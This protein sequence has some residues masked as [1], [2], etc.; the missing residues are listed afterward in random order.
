MHDLLLGALMRIH[1]R[2]VRVAREILILMRNGYAEGALARW[3]TLPSW[4]FRRS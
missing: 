3:R 4:S 2:S 1:S